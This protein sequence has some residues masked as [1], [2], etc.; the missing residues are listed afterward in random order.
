MSDLVKYQQD[1]IIATFKKPNALQ[2]AEENLINAIKRALLTCYFELNQAV[3]STIDLSVLVNK[4][5][6]SIQEKYTSLRADEIAEAFSNGI[7]KQYGEYYGLCLISFEQF[8]GGY[9]TDPRRVEQAKKHYKSLESKPEPTNAEKFSTA[10]NICLEAYE[11]VKSGKVIG[12]TAVT[13]YTFIK[14]IGLLDGYKA[15]QKEAINML[16]GE[17]EKDIA[18]CM[19]LIKRRQLN[20]DLERL[21]EG[22]EKDALT[23]DQWSEVK[24]TGKVMVITQYLQDVSLED[25]LVELIDSKREFYL[26]NTK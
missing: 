22:I 6:D 21:K 18:F 23:P 3:P 7:R 8:I 25:N 16:I 12:L 15:D 1:K 10:K 24:R 13:V 2:E 9:L 19:D 14:S 20:L 26:N 17:K 4:I 5:L 11:K